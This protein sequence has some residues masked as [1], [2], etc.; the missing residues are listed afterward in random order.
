M[1]GKKKLLKKRWDN[2]EHFHNISKSSDHIHIGK[3][4]NVVPSIP[5]SIVEIIDIIDNEL[6][7]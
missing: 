1:D 7:F 5:I 2:A 6:S 4:E 3:D